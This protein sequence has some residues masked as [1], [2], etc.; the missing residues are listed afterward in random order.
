MMRYQVRQHIFSFRDRFTIKDEYDQPQYVVEGKFFTVGN[1]LTLFNV[2]GEEE[3]Y[4]EQKLLR[5]LPE[6]YFY[7]KGKHIATIKKEFTFF[8]PKFHIASV[9]GNYEIQGN[10]L[11]YDF[12][13]LNHQ[14]VVCTISKRWFSFADTYGVEIKEDEDPSFMLALV[15][16]LDQVYHE[17]TNH[18][19]NHSS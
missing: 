12:Q 11:A 4:I 9:K 15:I 1:K 17:E 10:V 2:K 19:T 13:I 14:E 7:K 16:I 5:F 6:Y 18:S 8:K 3:I